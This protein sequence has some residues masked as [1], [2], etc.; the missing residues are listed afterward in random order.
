MSAS[1]PLHA[2][3][4]VNMA[5]LGFGVDDIKVK[6]GL[7]YLRIALALEAANEPALFPWVALARKRGRRT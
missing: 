5:R 2:S 7:S 3:V 4:A 1:W 6:T